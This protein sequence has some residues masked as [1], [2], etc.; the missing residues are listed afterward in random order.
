MDIITPELDEIIESRVRI[1]NF[2]DLAT[3]HLNWV[4]E[5]LYDKGLRRGDI[6]F[7]TFDV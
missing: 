1:I 3:P 2:F 7:L 6:I 5:Y 4:C